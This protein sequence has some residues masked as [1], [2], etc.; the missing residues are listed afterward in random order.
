MTNQVP[1]RLFF[2]LAR[3]APVG[4][5]F[6]RGPSK[7]VQLI[8]WDTRSDS[9][10]YGQWFHGRIYE[11]RCDLSP[12]GKLYIYFASKQTYKQWCSSYTGTWTA[13]SKP[14]YLTA[15]ALWP[16]GDCWGGGG[17]FHNNKTVRLN[18]HH[19]VGSQ[20]HPDHQPPKQLTVKVNTNNYSLVGEDNP[21]YAA[22]LER[23]G[24]RLTDSG[25]WHC[26]RWLQR[27]DP[28]EVR[29]KEQPQGSTSLIMKL[30]GRNS[31]STNG[32]WLYSFWLRFKNSGRE[33]PIQNAVWADWDCK[34]RLVFAREGRL[35]EAKILVDGNL[36]PRQLADFNNSKPQP[37]DSPNKAKSW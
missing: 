27:C 35:F 12:D 7:W 34:G 26:E 32:V 36:A 9:F 14:P 28:P 4:V 24:W 21:L 16:H 11:R 2:I 6:R 8:K 29:V 23:D 15:L 13:I 31:K 18:N 5:I 33:I 10:E 20:P 19:S 25:Q 37:L 30:H 3:Q 22:R 1:C 17:M